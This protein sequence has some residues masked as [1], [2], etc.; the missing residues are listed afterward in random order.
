MNKC[1]AAV[2]LFQVFF[3]GCDNMTALFSRLVVVLFRNVPVVRVIRNARTPLVLI[4]TLHLKLEK[5][6]KK[7]KGK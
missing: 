5:E 3:S 1:S 2:P 4:V 7:T 6:K